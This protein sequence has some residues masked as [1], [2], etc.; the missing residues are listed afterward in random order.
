MSNELRLEALAL[1]VNDMDQNT[2]TPVIFTQATVRPGPPLVVDFR[3]VP[4]GHAMV[5]P[6]TPEAAIGLLVALNDAINKTVPV[7]DLHAKPD[8]ILREAATPTK[9]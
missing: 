2:P 6:L 7:L 3:T 8:A 5:I 9:G 4:Q 1:K